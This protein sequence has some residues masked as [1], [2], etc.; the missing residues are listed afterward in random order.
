MPGRNRTG[1]L[2]KGPGTGRGAGSCTGS[3]DEGLSIKLL[4]FVFQNWRPILAFLMTT[5][6]PLIGKKV[7]KLGNE[8]KKLPE[9]TVTKIENND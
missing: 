7:L 1:P 8:T 3:A 5:L 2:G 4:R 6:V 9:L